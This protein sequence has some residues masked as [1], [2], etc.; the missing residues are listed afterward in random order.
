M[1]EQADAI[2]VGAG[3][4]GLVA[5]TELADA[6]KR[7]IVVEQEEMAVG[8]MLRGHLSMIP[9]LPLADV[10]EGADEDANALVHIRGEQPAFAF[11]PKE[12]DTIGPA[13]GL[14][15]E[16]G[17]ALSGA[18]FTFVRGAAARLHRALGAFMLDVLTRDHGYEETVPPVL[19]RQEAMFGTSQLP[20]FAE[21]SFQTTDGRWLIPTSEVSLTNSVREKILSEEAL[22]LRFTA[23]SPCF[24]SEAMRRPF[25]WNSSRVPPP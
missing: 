3:L 13:L 25:R 10:P 19:V 7:V 20:K 15:F 21:D 2:V 18:R 24:R 14:D 8:N 5:A 22:P 4:A 6:G 11:A 17:A 16:T 12:H 9:N 1:A 23:L